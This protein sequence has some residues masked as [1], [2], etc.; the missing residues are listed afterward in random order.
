MFSPLK[1]A[2][3]ELSSCLLILENRPDTAG[4]VP[5]QPLKSTTHRGNEH[6]I[7][8]VIYLLSYQQFPFPK[9]TPARV[10]YFSLRFQQH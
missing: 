4:D 7:A 5:A 3:H 9:Q 2:I 1:A 8:I 10:E 6:I